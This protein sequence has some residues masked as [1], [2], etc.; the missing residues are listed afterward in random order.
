M[1]SIRY[2]LVEFLI[3][4]IFLPIVFALQFSIWIKLSIGVIGFIYIIFIL[5]KIENNKFKISSHINWIAF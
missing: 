4:F 2:K 5:V 3:I 1:T